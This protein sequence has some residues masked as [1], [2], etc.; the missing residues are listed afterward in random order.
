MGITIA[1]PH[2]V[3][4]AVKKLKT[5]NHNTSASAVYVNWQQ[6]SILK[7]P[8]MLGS[9]PVLIVAWNNI[10]CIHNIS[11]HFP[12][13]NVWKSV[14]KCLLHG[15][16]QTIRWINYESILIHVNIHRHAKAC[17]SLRIGIVLWNISECTPFYYLT[18]GIKESQGGTRG[19]G[20]TGIWNLS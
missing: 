6:F 8:P 20:Q 3:V 2:W 5:V 9:D 18:Q 19:L 13:K 12:I 16:Y 17:S 1:L 11:S 7:R 10:R 14:Y 4:M 15:I